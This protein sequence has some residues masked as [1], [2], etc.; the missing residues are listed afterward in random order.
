MTVEMVRGRDGQGGNFVWPEEAEDVKGKEEEE[1]GKKE[2]RLEEQR[3]RVTPDE[4]YKLE[5]VDA[6]GLRER[7][8]LLLLGRARW[9]PSWEEDG[10][11]AAV[12]MGRE[13]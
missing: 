12:A 5:P 13:G 9:R 10:G 3:R 8:R 7:A 6:K 1:D 4:R 11:A 2:K